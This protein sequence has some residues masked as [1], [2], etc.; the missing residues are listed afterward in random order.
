MASAPVSQT[1]TITEPPGNVAPTPVNNLPACSALVCNF[2]GVGS[3]DSTVG[4]SFTYLWDF[5]DA[6]P[7]STSTS[8]SHTFPRRA[9]TR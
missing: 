3:A 4:D 1:V 7:T 2:S 8:P 6:T 5:G 9:P